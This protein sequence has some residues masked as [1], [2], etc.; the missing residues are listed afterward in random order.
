MKQRSLG[1][2]EVGAIGLGAMPMTTEDVDAPRAIETIHAALN[3][4]VTLIDTADAYGPPGTGLG[5]NESLVA[6]ALAAWDGDAGSILVATKGGA[7]RADDGS[8][9]LDGRPDRLIGAARAS[10]ERLGVERLDLWQW[11]RPDPE[12]P[13]S[14]SLAALHAIV[15]E[16]VAA[17]VGLSNVD[18]EQIRHA[19]RVLG[20]ALVSV[21]NRFSPGYRSSAMELE[22]CIELGLAFLPYSPLGGIGDAPTLGVDDGVFPDAAAELGISAQRLA[23]AW[24]LSLAHVVIPIPGASRP[25]SIRDSALAAAVEL[26]P[27]MVGRLSAGAYPPVVE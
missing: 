3:S 21:Q 15:A 13:F 16:G 22:T 12:V 1:H 17:A 20:P 8:W 27:E 11:H 18:S 10:A 2:R 14:D 25:E 19:H 6:E 23:L 26:S 4:G 24:E 5:V 9:G 7:T